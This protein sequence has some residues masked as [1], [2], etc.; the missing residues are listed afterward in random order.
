M[1]DAI[2]ICLTTPQ[3][4]R[5]EAHLPD[6]VCSKLTYDIAGGFLT[7]DCRDID[8]SGFKVLIDIA[9]KHCPELVKEIEKQ[10]LISD[11]TRNKSN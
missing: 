9:T 10:K 6:G 11:R 2:T 4:D 5:L 3:W 1:A 8:E 7:V